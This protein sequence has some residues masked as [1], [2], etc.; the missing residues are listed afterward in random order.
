MAGNSLSKSP[1]HL[2]SGFSELN[3]KMKAEKKTVLVTGANGFIGRALC[4]QLAQENYSVKAMLR[5]ED[6]LPKGLLDPN[7]EFLIGDITDP[8]SLKK[9]FVGLDAVCHLAGIAHVNHSSEDLLL[10]TN[11]DGSRNVAE[12]AKASR[13]K[14]IIYMSSS[15]ASAAELG[16]GDITDYGKSKFLAEVQIQDTLEGS[17]TNFAIL[18]PANVYGEGM[19]GN[20]AAMINL[21]NRH[22]L[23]PLPKLEN[24]ISLLGVDDLTQAIILSLK[25]HRANGKV[26]T[27]SDGMDYKINDIEA[28]IYGG[29]GRKSP[30]WRSPRMVLY[31]AAALAELAAKAGLKV[32]GIGLRTYRNLVQDNQ[33]SNSKIS[34]D[35]GF[36]PSMSLYDA[37]PEIIQANSGAKPA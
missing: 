14:K 12:Q 4:T 2:D 36:K 13:V 22:R 26:Y 5:N 33:V 34:E 25:N 32:S 17:D 19:K 10:E 1:D 15:L 23:P 21:I 37:L 30:A 7:I 16:S 6:S 29:L 31:G 24:Q 27:V 28:A 3:K 20:I 18:R 8:K 9:I 11:V 35:I